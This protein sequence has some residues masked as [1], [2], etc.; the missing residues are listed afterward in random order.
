MAWKDVGE[1]IKLLSV[2]KINMMKRCAKQFEFRY[3]KGI[4][5]PPTCS[6]INGISVHESAN[7]NYEQKKKSKKDMSFDVMADIFSD[8]FKDKEKELEPL[9]ALGASKAYD[10]G[11]KMLRKYRDKVATKTQPVE[12]EL[13][14]NLPLIDKY[15]FIGYVDLITDK[16]ALRDTKTAGQ[17]YGIEKAYISKLT[18]LSP[19]YFICKQIPALKDKVNTVALDVVTPKDYQPFPFKPEMWEFDKFKDDAT[20][21]AKL[22]QT[23][24]FLPCDDAQTCGWCGYKT[25][26]RNSKS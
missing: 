10:N 22:I 16:K 17:K 6:L 1:D 9:D 2:S 15:S 24:I 12:T 7:K 19:Y 13:E 4:K 14:L 21:V 11:I 25:M 18:Q 23:G 5:S 20:K 26:C 8:T 3:I